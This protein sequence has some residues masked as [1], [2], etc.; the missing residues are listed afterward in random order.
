MI[1]ALG[2]VEGILEHTLFRV[3]SSFIIFSYLGNIF[4]HLGRFVLGAC[5]RFRRI[6][7][8]QETYK[9][10]KIRFEP[11]SQSSV[12]FVVVTNNQQS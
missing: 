11:D 12:Y 1:Q 6:D 10:A 4:P 7:E 5:L 2:G 3:S 8:I 9:C